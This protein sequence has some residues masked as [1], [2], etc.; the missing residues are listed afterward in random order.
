M[1]AT[2][3]R[4][5]S[6]GSGPAP[7]AVSFDPE[8]QVDDILARRPAVGL[9]LGVV[10]DGR[11]ESFVGRGLADVA[12]GAS[13][14]EDTLFRI[15]SIS[16]TFT[17]IAIMQ[18][19]EQG[20]VDLD[21]PAS[22]SLRAFR[23]IPARPG[24]RP[25]RIRDL[26][27]H[28]AG[29]PELLR[30]SDL[31]KP[32]WGDSVRVGEPIPS[33]ADF[34][35]GAIRL[36]AEPGT[37]FTYTNHGFAALQQVV[38]DV[39]GEPFDRYLRDHL[40]APLGMV[41]SDI[42]RSP[43]VVSRL[44][45][46]YTIGSQGAKPVVERDWVTAGAS[47]IYSTIR[48]MSRYI[49]ALLGG[50][51]NAHGTV[52]RPAT[53]AMMFEPQYQPDP[54]VPGMG[55]GFDRGLAGGHPIV[56][57]GGIL[58]GFNSQLF[59]APDDGVGVIAFTNGARLAM[60]WLPTE[61]G[62]VLAHRL[63]VEDDTLRND[64]PHHP[65]TW[66]DLCGW[67]AN[68]AKITDIRAQLMLGAGAEVFVRGDRLVLRL[69]SPMPAFYRGFELHPDDPTDPDVFR[70]D[71]TGFGLPTARIIFSREPGRPASAVH[72]DIFPVSLRR[73]PGRTN[74]RLWVQAGLVGLGAVSTAVAVRRRL[75]ARAR[76]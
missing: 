44:A 41:E 31:F 21:A 1:T 2:L 17:A 34:Y 74:P 68:P 22:E 36:D 13:I 27:T 71:L 53:L 11:L 70:V 61:L 32:D 15:A 45:T 10:R 9:A 26:L 37:R 20:L 69:L 25:A 6:E 40:L 63:G 5:M 30:P 76:P 33:L 18:L 73:R 66:G 52:L 7:A 62:R 19:W 43:L 4:A 14:T 72:L 67:Y 16:K 48:D 50:G 58:P 12:T 28:T 54:R 49:A 8:A 46:G 57:H 75:A 64:V 55:L 60:L 24:D 29:V 39:S 23:L 65:E 47:S 56:G 42:V 3:T 35:R 59:V 51:S 38:E